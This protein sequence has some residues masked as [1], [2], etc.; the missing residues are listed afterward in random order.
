MARAFHF[1]FVS[2]TRNEI[3]S[4]PNCCEE[5]DSS[6]TMYNQRR[7]GEGQEHPVDA[8]L[9]HHPFNS[10]SQ[11]APRMHRP[12]PPPPIHYPAHVQQRQQ[13]QQQQHYQHHQQQNQHQQHSTATAVYH[14]Q[15]F[16]HG[17]SRSPAGYAP[18]ATLSMHQTVHRSQPTSAPALVSPSTNHQAD[19]SAATSPVPETPTLKLCPREVVADV[20]GSGGKHATPI[21]P[22]DSNPTTVEATPS[23]HS[24]ATTNNVTAHNFVTTKPPRPYTEYTMFYQLEREYILHR[25]LT[26]DHEQALQN[27][28][29]GCTETQLPALFQNDPLMPA[30]YC[31]LPLRADWYISGK[32]KK[33]TKRK[34][35]KS[36]GKIGFLELTRMIAARWAKV[37]DETRKYCKMMAAMELVKYREDMESYEA[38]KEHLRAVG[39]IPEDMKERM[40]KKQRVQEKRDARASSKL[41]R[42]KKQGGISGVNESASSIIEAATITSHSSADVKSHR[43]TFLKAVK[44]EPIAHNSPHE[45]GNLDNAMEEFITSLVHDDPLEIPKS[46]AIT[47]EHSK[48]KSRLSHERPAATPPVARVANIPAAS[49][50][51]V[52]SF[53]ALSKQDHGEDLDELKMAFSGIDESEIAR[54]FSH[55]NR[56]NLAGATKTSSVSMKMDSSFDYWDVLVEST[57]I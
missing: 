51:T 9:G 23:R 47:P 28:G 10:H 57:P 40:L 31:S 37:D 30:R 43:G 42:Q 18:Q 2:R 46:K 21:H 14:H 54:E 6:V 13:Q 20:V 48:K 39:E 22:I 56:T 4:E 1:T 35:R 24:S 49:A 50:A 19:G 29:D 41:N 25:I 17:N 26:T 5:K 12:P 3:C 36:H 27:P 52:G 16:Y 53:Q 34:H 15:S 44:L 38:Y 7:R 55:V 33:P 11:A 45:T 8:W 32:S